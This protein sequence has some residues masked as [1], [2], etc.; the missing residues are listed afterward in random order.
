MAI[1]N[2]Y[3]KLPYHPM[4]IMQLNYWYSIINSNLTSYPQVFFAYQL[5]AFWETLEH[6]VYNDEMKQLCYK[7]NNNDDYKTKI[8]SHLSEL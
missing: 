8:V 4:R 1:T 2:I 7:I 3:L 6:F 5:A